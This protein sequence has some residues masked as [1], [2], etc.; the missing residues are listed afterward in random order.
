[1]VMI[2]NYFEVIISIS[3]FWY[4]CFVWLRRIVLCICKDG[5][6]DFCRGEGFVGD[7]LLLGV[8]DVGYL[9]KVYKLKL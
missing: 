3:E 9:C 5:V 7:G 2:Y 8:I 1:M 6:F 4:E